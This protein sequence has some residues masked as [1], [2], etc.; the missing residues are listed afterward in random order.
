VQDAGSQIVTLAAKAAPDMRIVDLC[1][2]AGGKTLALAAA[3]G[4]PVAR[5]LAT[6]VPIAAGC[7]RLAPSARRGRGRRS[8]RPACSIPSAGRP[9]QLA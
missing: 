6:D 5:I 1:A 8:P 2:G 7:Q 4:Q 3:D 9:K